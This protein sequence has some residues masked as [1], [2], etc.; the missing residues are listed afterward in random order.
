MSSNVSD[1]VPAGPKVNPE[2]RPVAELAHAMWFDGVDDTLD[3]LLKAG[4]EPEQSSTGS[5][6]LVLHRALKVDPQAASFKQRS[7]RLCNLQDPTRYF[8]EGMPSH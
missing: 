3:F 1:S 5:W 4:L 7:A 8:A 6:Q 2:T